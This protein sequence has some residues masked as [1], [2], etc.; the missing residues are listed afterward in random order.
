MYFIDNVKKEDLKG[1]SVSV[2][3]CILDQMVEDCFPVDFP[4]IFVDKVDLVC[5]FENIEEYEAFSNIIRY[6]DIEFFIS[7]AHKLSDLKESKKEEREID[8]R[9]GPWKIQCW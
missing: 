1:I 2:K 8:W 6:D 5:V 4:G 9:N 7:P 3:K